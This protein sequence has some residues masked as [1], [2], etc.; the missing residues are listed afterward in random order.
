MQLCSCVYFLYFNNI[1]LVDNEIQ[2]KIVLKIFRDQ[3]VMLY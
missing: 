2:I 1:S 3:N